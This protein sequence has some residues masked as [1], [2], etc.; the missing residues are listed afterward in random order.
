MYQA[1]DESLLA[2][3]VHRLE[4]R[5]SSLNR[6]GSQP[7]KHEAATF[8]FILD[9]EKRRLAELIR[10]GQRQNDDPPKRHCPG[11]REVTPLLPIRG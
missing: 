5:I 10:Q 9:S 7:A 11:A 6:E 4:K 8:Q 3:E 1:D 2:K